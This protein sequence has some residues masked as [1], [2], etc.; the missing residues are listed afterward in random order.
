M[1]A[2]CFQSVQFILFPFLCFIF[3]L[4]LNQMKKVIPHI[5]YQQYIHWWVSANRNRDYLIWFSLINGKKVSYI[6]TFSNIG[7]VIQRFVH[8]GSILSCSMTIEK[9]IP[10]IIVM[11]EVILAP[12]LNSHS[13]SFIYDRMLMINSTIAGFI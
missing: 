8:L 6:N 7:C 10:N 13:L 9:I 12:I 4:V 11:K 2:I 1:G 5:G 3:F